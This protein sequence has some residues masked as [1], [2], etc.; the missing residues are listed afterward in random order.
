MADDLKN[1][2][3]RTMITI[4]EVDNGWRY[5]VG[6]RDDGNYSNAHEALW[7]CNNWLSSH[8]EAKVERE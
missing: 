2:R 3:L 7:A 8:P 6:W 1:P 4:Y 5:R